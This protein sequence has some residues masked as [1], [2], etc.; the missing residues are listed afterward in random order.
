MSNPEKKI[1]LI[2]WDWNG[3]LL[4]DVDCC[5]QAINCMLTKRK[6]PQITTAEYKQLFTFPVIDY[7]KEI[8]FDF[9]KESFE[10]VSVEFMNGYF[11]NFNFARLS[12]CTVKVLSS[13]KNRGIQQFILSAMKQE[14]LEKTVF[15]FGIRSYFDDLFG[16]RDHYANGKIDLAKRV[17]NNKGFSNHNAMLIGDSLH[18]DEVAT[19]LGIR[20]ILYSQGHFSRERL[21][22]AGKPLI[23]SL[24]DVLSLSAIDLDETTSGYPD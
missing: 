8:G 3:T 13:L 22:S 9:E 19:E 10:T 14:D 12:P 20:C 2:F 18:D 23:D 6:L 24:E 1:D 21:A 11:E 4:N 7:Y 17:F 15:R 5:L 16:A